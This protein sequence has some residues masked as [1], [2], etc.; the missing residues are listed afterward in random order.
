VRLWQ[1]GGKQPEALAVLPGCTGWIQDVEF[2][3]DGKLLAAASGAG[4]H[5]W[6]VETRTVKD[7]L[8]RADSQPFQAESVAFAPKRSLLATGGLYPALL[9]N[10]FDGPAEKPVAW[11]SGMH[12]Q[13]LA[14]SPDGNSIVVGGTGGVKVVTTPGARS[15]V[16]QGSI[17]VVDI[18]AADGKFT[19][20]ATL[21]SAGLVESVAWSPDGSH[22]ACANR[23]GAIDLWKAEDG[24]FAD[25]AIALGSHEGVASCVDFGAAGKW[26]LSAGADGQI[27]LWDVATGKKQREWAWP[28]RV[29]VVKFAP[30]GKHFAVGDSSG[31]A[32]LVR[33]ME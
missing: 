10:D 6:D 31:R 23:N 8:N 1:L 19:P 14:F 26:L 4:T 33:V 7:V 27:V 17:A 30:D 16:P 5:C 15:F 22:I 28:A 11:N 3:H 25:P 18:N 24:Q 9:L 2:S 12:H 13:K 29:W 21:Q 20:R 32:F